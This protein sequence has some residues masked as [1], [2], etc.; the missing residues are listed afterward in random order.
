[1]KTLECHWWFRMPMIVGLLIGLAGFGTGCASGPDESESKLDYFDGGALQDPEPMTLV[2]TGRVLKS[3]GR[4]NESEYILRRV[5]VEYPEFVPGYT[6]LSELLL[7][8][9]RTGEA[10]VVLEQGISEQPGNAMLHN[11]LGMCK[12]V[13]R[14]FKDARSEFARARDL[15][16]VEATY[17]ANLA[18][19]NGL[20]GNYDLAV[21]LYLQVLPVSDAH[22]NVARLAE[23]QGDMERARSDL[24]IAARMSE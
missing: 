17:T 5:I 9:G 10:I 19:V 14:D 12:L 23:A 22:T 11:D 16:P 20:L 6:E 18:M 13:A 8:D 2:M 3:Q 15:D 7:K 24:A 1:M 21:E 4:L